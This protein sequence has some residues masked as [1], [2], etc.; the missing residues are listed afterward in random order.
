MGLILWVNDTR[1]NP[2]GCNSKVTFTNSNFLIPYI[3]LWCYKSGS[4]GRGPESK[5]AN[6]SYWIENCI[7]INILVCMTQPF[8]L[9]ISWMHICSCLPCIPHMLSLNPSKNSESFD[10]WRGLLWFQCFLTDWRQPCIECILNQY[11][12][13][14]L[15]YHNGQYLTLCHVK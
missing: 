8:L 9:V 1:F 2:L 13:T 12:Q 5:K 14:L 6:W 11:I 4:G 10:W 7:L 3:L 15:I